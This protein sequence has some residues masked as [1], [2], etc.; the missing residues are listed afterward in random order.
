MTPPTPPPTRDALIASLTRRLGF[1]TPQARGRDSLDFAEVH[2]ER[3]LEALQEA[4]DA[5]R[6]AG[7]GTGAR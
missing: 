3:L 1:E 5:G 6:N 7:G 2:V 4:Y